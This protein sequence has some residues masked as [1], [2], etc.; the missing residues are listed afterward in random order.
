MA[1]GHG[2]ALELICTGREVDATEMDCIGLVQARHPRA[3]VKD[4]GHAMAQTIGINGPLA[5]RGA[6]RILRARRDPGFAEARA[7]L[8][9]LRDALEWSEDVDE[10]LAAH[11]EGRAAVFKGA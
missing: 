3:L 9:E 4:A 6:K 5:T 8:D 1:V 7:L 11:R 10:D 2:R